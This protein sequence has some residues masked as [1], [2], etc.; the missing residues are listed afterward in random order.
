MV[1]QRNVRST[2][3]NLQ[4]LQNVVPLD[5]WPVH[6]RCMFLSK[7]SVHWLVLDT[8]GSACSDGGPEYAVSTLNE[9]ICIHI[10]AT[11]AAAQQGI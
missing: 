7:A 1:K 5:R 6:D 9:A 3:C 4:K 8:C 11:T 2:T 10:T